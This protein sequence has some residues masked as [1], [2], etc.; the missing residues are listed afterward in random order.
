MKRSATPTKNEDRTT[1]NQNRLNA[2]LSAQRDNRESLQE[3]TKG[4]ASYN[5]GIPY[6]SPAKTGLQNGAAKEAQEAERAS[7]TRA[8]NPTALLDKVVDETMQDV[9]DSADV[10]KQPD[11]PPV[12]VNALERE[13]I[14]NNVENTPGSSS[15]V[16]PNIAIPRTADDAANLPGPVLNGDGDPDHSPDVVHL[17]PKEEQEKRLKEQ[18]EMREQR[19]RD[20][21]TKENTDA[22]GKLT[23]QVPNLEAPTNGHHDRS[24]ERRVGKECPV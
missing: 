5:F 20:E 10:D 24:E 11:E 4:D 1:A 12:P 13:N 17:P 7:E 6:G 18:D 14:I 9:I 16:D 19:K 2:L 23:L 22:N 3:R 21:E 15:G 8:S